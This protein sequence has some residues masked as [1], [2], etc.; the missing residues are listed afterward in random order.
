MDF[1]VFVTGNKL[2]FRTPCNIASNNRYVIKT[3]L[4]TFQLKLTVS[5][6]K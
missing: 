1:D 2:H 3:F 5:K 4:D 6:L